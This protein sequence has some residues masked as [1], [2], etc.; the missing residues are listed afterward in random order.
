M[1]GISA[2]THLRL[3]AK[4]LAW[5][6]LGD[7]AVLVQLEKD[8]IHVAN[9]TGALLVERLSQGAS[10]RE[11]TE[12]VTERFDVSED[13]ARRDVE[14]FIGELARADAIEERETTACP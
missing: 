8:E 4:S 10:I 12:L 3:R 6:A 11:L 2:N 14:A 7:E 13:Q 5:S 1:V 9:A